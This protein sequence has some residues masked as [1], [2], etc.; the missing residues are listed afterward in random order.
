MAFHSYPT[1]PVIAKVHLGQN[2]YVSNNVII[3]NGV[4]FKTMYQYMVIEDQVFCGPSMVFTN[5]KVP[6]SEFLK[7]MLKNIK[8]PLLKNQLH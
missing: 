1:K 2:V 3:G 7:I 6:R 5:I 4:K 8:R